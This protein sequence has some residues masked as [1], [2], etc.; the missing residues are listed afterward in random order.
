MR[1][2][3]GFFQLFSSGYRVQDVQ[4]SSGDY[5]NGPAHAS[6]HFC[7]PSCMRL[8]FQT[9]CAVLRGRGLRVELFT[10]FLMGGVTRA[11][12]GGT[13]PT[14][15][16]SAEKSPIVWRVGPVLEFLGE[17]EVADLDVSLAVEQDVLGLEVAV[18][19][20]Q[21]VQVVEDERDLSRVEHGR[22]RVEPTGVAQ[23]REQLAAADVLEHHVQIAVVVLRAQPAH[24]S[25]RPL[26][27]GRI[28]V[29]RTYRCGLLLQT[30]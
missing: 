19:D 9:V 5:A 27:R 8:G 3:Q 13:S 6:S 18:D 16:G 1:R 2:V 30:E 21:R 14:L 12:G 25:Q 10:H 23:V 17:A 24:H 15:R 28:A 4:S 20:G 22:R 7:S 26:L 11:Q 29:P